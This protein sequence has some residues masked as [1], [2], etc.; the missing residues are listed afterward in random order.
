M[1]CI[2]SRAQPIGGG[3]NSGFQALNLALQWGARK[4]I[5]VGF[6][7]TDE[8]G[9]HWYG[10][11]SVEGRQQSGRRLLP[12][13]ARCLRRGAGG[14][15][16]DRRRRRQLLAADRDE[17]LSGDDDRRGAGEVCV[18]IQVVT[19]MNAAAWQQYG[20]R[21]VDSF[22]AKW[23]AA[24]TLDRLQP[25]LRHHRIGTGASAVNCRHGWPTSRRI[26]DSPAAHGIRRG[27][28]DY[29]FDAVKFA[30]KVAALT[31]YG[32]TLTSGM[33]IW[34]DADTFTHADVTE[35]WLQKLF[36]LP[37][38]IAWLDRDEQPSGM[39]VHHVP[40]CRSVSS[41]IHAGL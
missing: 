22:L 35:A 12:P 38:Y 31:D 23:P 17:D 7:L 40:A 37:A 5:L 18:K 19:T 1:T 20:R 6:D 13:L 27:A 26:Y 34:L 2:R 4:I 28:Y 9:L 16:A 36:P 11:N 30:H 41:Q 3:G 14:A 15:G 8:N 25:G 39:R 24:A 32:K 10:R 21:M 33:M 29:R